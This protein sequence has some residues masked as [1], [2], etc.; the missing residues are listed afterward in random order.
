[1]SRHRSLRI[2]GPTF[3]GRPLGHQLDPLRCIPNKLQPIVFQ[4]L[5]KRLLEE[6]GFK[7]QHT[8]EQDQ[9]LDYVIP[10]NSVQL[11]LGTLYYTYEWVPNYLLSLER[12]QAMIFG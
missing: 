3:R 6:H 9:L 8:V 4:E 1:M 11:L 7:S 5:V 12:L 10:P 2:D